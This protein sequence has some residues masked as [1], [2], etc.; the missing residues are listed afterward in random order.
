MYEFVL[1]WES[2][3]TR[4]NRVTLSTQNWLESDRSDSNGGVVRL[5][6]KKGPVPLF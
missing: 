2:R 1:R 3:L 4:A 6:T 5:E